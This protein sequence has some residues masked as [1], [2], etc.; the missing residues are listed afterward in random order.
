[1]AL[2]PSAVE[3]IDRTFLNLLTLATH[4]PEGTAGDAALDLPADAEA[5]LLV[6][7]ERDNARAARGVVGDA[8][9]A[10]RTVAA[11]VATALTPAEERQL[12]T[13]RH[14]TS[15]I[16]ASL[17]PDRRSLQIVEDGCVPLPR[18]GEYIQAI[19]QSAQAN[20]ITVVVFGHAGDGNVHVNAIP[21]LARSDWQGRVRSLYEEVND[22]AIRLGGTVSGEHGDGRLRAPLLEKLYGPEIVG[23][24]HKVKAAFDP[25]GIFNPGVKLASPGEAIT[26]LKLGPDA[27]LIPDDIAS[28]LREI[29]RTGGYA[30][31]RLEIAEGQVPPSDA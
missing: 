17:P 26:R 16:L 23:L 10:V 3:L 25:D 8:V 31:S 5:V 30:R 18:L 11:D 2:D 9:R 29:E 28:A 13:L 24:F 6:E 20:G 14:A 1:V 19:R 21:E 27:A 4:A 15:P 12:W 22:A 7:F